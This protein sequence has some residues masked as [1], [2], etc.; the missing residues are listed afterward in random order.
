M[1][2]VNGLGL[3]GPTPERSLGSLDIV[4]LQRNYRIGGALRR[5]PVWQLPFG[6]SPLI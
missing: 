4:G 1:N 3:A 2:R 6:G 5:A